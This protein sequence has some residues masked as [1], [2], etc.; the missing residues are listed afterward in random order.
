MDNTIIGERLAG[1]FDQSKGTNLET[2]T[3]WD[4]LGDRG[5]Q[6]Y[7]GI[8]L[9]K[10]YFWFGMGSGNFRSIVLDTVCVLHSEYLIQFL[11]CGFIAAILYFSVYLWIIKRTFNIKTRVDEVITIKRFILLSMLALLFACLVTRIS[12]YGAYSCY[13]AYMIFYL[14]QFLSNKHYSG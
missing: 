4:Y 13:L 14:K 1:T 9:I 7:L 8:P 6:Y 5:Y 2:G 11:E 12:Y 3:F 10:H